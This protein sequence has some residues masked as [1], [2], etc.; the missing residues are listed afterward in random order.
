MEPTISDVDKKID[1]ILQAIDNQNQKL[2]GKDGYKGDIV[3]ISEWEESC[4]RVL[5]ELRGVA[6]TNHEKICVLEATK[7]GWRD[8]K[9]IALIVGAVLAASGISVGIAEGIR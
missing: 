3:R 4:G 9:F 2:W 7:L 5:E 6:K 1:L 8:W